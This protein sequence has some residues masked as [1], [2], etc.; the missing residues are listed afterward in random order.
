MSGNT[1]GRPRKFYPIFVYGRV[2]SITEGRTTAERHHS[3]GWAFKNRIAAEEFAA[4]WNYRHDQ[5]EEIA[6]AARKERIA[7]SRVKWADAVA[8][9]H[10]TG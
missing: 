7:A 10:T 1:R 2:A 5:E 3:T 9:S 8:A 6:N 4:W